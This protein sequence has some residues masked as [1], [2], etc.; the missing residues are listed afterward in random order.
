[1]ASGGKPT[2]A[3]CWLLQNPENL[4]GTVLRRIVHGVSVLVSATEWRAGS[5]PAAHPSQ[6]AV[7]HSSFI[8]LRPSLIALL[9]APLRARQK[10]RF[11]VRWKAS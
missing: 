2:L 5:R 9:K 8:T 7:R 10:A 6:P 1:M 11:R 4:G 3:V